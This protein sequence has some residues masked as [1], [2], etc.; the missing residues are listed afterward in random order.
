MTRVTLFSWILV[1]CGFTQAQK[2]ALKINVTNIKQLQGSIM[3]AVYDQ[4]EKFLSQQV[5]TS[6]KQAVVNNQMSIVLDD[7]NFGDYAISI[8]HDVNG[9]GELD[10]NFFK[11][12]KEPYG[13]SNNS[14]GFFNSPPNYDKALFAFGAHM[15]EIEI[16]LN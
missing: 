3:V 12:P 1:V 8:Y 14:M 7:L 6:T 10:F 11:I 16:R 9:N 13:F 4:K 5:V 2:K 15:D